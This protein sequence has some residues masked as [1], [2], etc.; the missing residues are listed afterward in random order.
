MP[1]MKPITLWGH[2][3]APNPLKVAIILCELDIPHE[4]KIVAFEDVKQEPFLKLNPNGRMPAIEDP[5]TGIVLWESGAIIEYLIETYDTENKLSYA[6]SPEKWAQSSWKHLQMSGQGPY[7]GQLV[8]FSNFHQ[9]KLPSVISRYEKELDRVVSVLELQLTR[10][11]KPYLVGDKCTYADL[12]FIPWHRAIPGQ[13]TH[14]FFTKT[15]PEKYPVSY[16]WNQRL[17]ARDGAKKAL[18]DGQKLMQ[19]SH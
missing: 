2:P 5:N 15:W 9:E 14:D 10:T 16:E 17:L 4:I 8:W 1:D 7:Y 19:R 6:D 12:M 3:F 11:G 13:P 18:A